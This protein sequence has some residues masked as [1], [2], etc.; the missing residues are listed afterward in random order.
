[1]GLTK[2]KKNYERHVS[3]VSC[4]WMMKGSGCGM[5]FSRFCFCWSGQEWQL[6]HGK[7]KVLDRFLPSLWLLN[8]TLRTHGRPLGRM[9]LSTNTRRQSQV[10]QQA[11][12]QLMELKQDEQEARKALRITLGVLSTVTRNRYIDDEKALLDFVRMFCV[13]FSAG[14]RNYAQ[15]KECRHDIHALLWQLVQVGNVMEQNCKRTI[16][17]V[18][19]VVEAIELI[20]NESESH[21]ME[22]VQLDS[23]LL[24]HLRKLYRRTHLKMPK[25][26]SPDRAEPLPDQSN[27]HHCQVHKRISKQDMEH[28]LQRMFSSGFLLVKAI[29]K[30]YTIDILNDHIHYSTDVDGLRKLIEMESTLNENEN[31]PSL[32]LTAQANYVVIMDT[33]DE[34][35]DKNTQKWDQV[36]ERLNEL[37]LVLLQIT[38]RLSRPPQSV[39]EILR[40]KAMVSLFGKLGYRLH[41]TYPLENTGDLR[42]YWYFLETQ[43]KY[44]D[45][46]F[47]KKVQTKEGIPFPLA[48]SMDVVLR[49]IR[50]H[51][52]LQ[53]EE[54]P[55]HEKNGKVVNKRQSEHTNI[56]QEFN[57]TSK[58]EIQCSLLIKVGIDSKAS[59]DL[60]DYLSR[61]RKLL[62]LRGI[63][64]RN[65][66][67]KT[68]PKTHPAVPVIARHIG[69]VQ[70]LC[71]VCQKRPNMAKAHEENSNEF[72]GART[73]TTVIAL[74]SS[75][76]RR[77]MS[78]EAS[79]LDDENTRLGK[80]AQGL[81][82]GTRITSTSDN[83]KYF[84]QAVNET[85]DL[86][87][88]NSL[89]TTSSDSYYDRSSIKSP[90]KKYDQRIRS[91]SNFRMERQQVNPNMFGMYPNYA[92][93]AN[94]EPRD[95]YEKVIRK[96]FL[97]LTTEGSK[98]ESTSLSWHGGVPVLNGDLVCGLKTYIKY[99]KSRSLKWEQIMDVTRILSNIILRDRKNMELSTKISNQAGGHDLLRRQA[100][101]N[102]V[103]TGHGAYA[104]G[105]HLGE[106]L[107]VLE[108]LISSLESTPRECTED[109]EFESILEQLLGIVVALI[110]WQQS[111]Q[112][113]QPVLDSLQN[114]Q[115]IITLLSMAHRLPINDQKRLLEWFI[116]SSRN[117]GMVHMVAIQHL[118]DAMCRRTLSA[119]SSHCFRPF[120][121]EAAST[122]A[123]NST[124][125]N[126]LGLKNR[127]PRVDSAFQ[128]VEF[129]VTTNDST[130][131]SNAVG[132]IALLS[133]MPGWAS[134]TLRGGYFDGEIFREQ[135]DNGLLSLRTNELQDFSSNIRKAEASFSNSRDKHIRMGKRHQIPSLL[136]IST[137]DCLHRLHVFCAWVIKQQQ[138]QGDKLE[139]M[140]NVEV[141]LR[142]IS[143]LLRA[144]RA[145]A[146]S[147][148]YTN[149]KT[150]KPRNIDASHFVQD[151]M[152]RVFR[153]VYKYKTK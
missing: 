68:D 90:L 88:Y 4:R 133:S 42:A 151:A 114:R 86:L 57:S 142:A 62:L 38:D 150:Y 98:W 6:I 130:E 54:T 103:P 96:C 127:E 59:A 16:G 17:S 152:E 5:V 145:S 111:V 13:L 100:I 79:S 67:D 91:V 75:A 112:T 31:I 131:A 37:R 2:D 40:S 35:L 85:C 64:R 45:D 3:S 65:Q 149:G 48:K 76:K 95:M 147:I 50:S 28:L 26:M 10:I 148:R 140:A 23:D 119:I 144:P 128:N 121:S 47:D 107:E 77:Y 93:S 124:L 46:F 61:V 97:L 113:F 44:L 136:P 108:C 137:V 32:F 14:N 141:P 146:S 143:E 22:F 73:R 87:S 78:S 18:T 74:G 12:C 21:G 123:G 94:E 92:V 29:E 139:T 89:V 9:H 60:T 135:E 8:T 66:S 72:L 138:Q 109:R 82:R 117:Y 1:M 58:R 63:H 43:L 120:I 80:L 56:L 84:L 19:A 101:L 24:A 27:H 33:L 11:T 105:G 115:S 69:E 99:L 20:Q 25:H 132:T 52:M 53:T 39:E 125:G 41:E 15:V 70:S 153:T 122:Q 71:S 55:N 102:D 34:L 7:H 104:V 134:K 116:G 129:S 30:C 81:E 36:F 118:A 126:G 110:K 106:L 51:C 83:A 49:C